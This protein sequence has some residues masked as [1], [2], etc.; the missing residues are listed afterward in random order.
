MKVVSA[1]LDAIL[2][3]IGIFVEVSTSLAG[4]RNL[5]ERLERLRRYSLISGFLF[6]LRLSSNYNPSYSVLRTVTM[7]SGYGLNGGKSSLQFSQ[8]FF[9]L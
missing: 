5:Y 9:S 8:E 6:N 3:C 2:H 1:S 7:A 4:V